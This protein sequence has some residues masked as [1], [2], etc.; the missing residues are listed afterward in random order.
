M[1]ERVTIVYYLTYSNLY[2]NYSLI[3]GGSMAAIIDPKMFALIPLISQG[4]QDATEM[5]SL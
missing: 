5:H 4:P 2:N 3:A 1:R